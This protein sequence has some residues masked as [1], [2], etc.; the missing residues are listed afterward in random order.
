MQGNNSAVRCIPSPRK[1]KQNKK[2]AVIVF[3][4]FELKKLFR[5]ET[6]LDRN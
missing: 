5:F 4:I 2:A 3:T 1:K 6:H